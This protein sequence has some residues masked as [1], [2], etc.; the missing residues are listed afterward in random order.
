[1]H[2]L[3]YNEEETFYLYLSI[4]KNTDFKKIYNNNLELLNKYIYFLKKYIEM[5]TPKIAQYLKDNIIEPSFFCQTWFFTLFTKY[6]SFFNINNYPKSIV[7]ILENFILDGYIAIFRAGITFLNYY[8]N[9]MILL[10]KDRFLKFLIN[11][12]SQDM[13]TNENF[14]LFR[15]LFEYNKNLINFEDFCLLENIYNFEI[16]I[17]EENNN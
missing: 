8:Q 6:N 13:I 1:M 11:D 15:N 16:K 3:N 14:N 2:L 4:I 12:M 5:Y 9:K 17:N 7:L 10:E